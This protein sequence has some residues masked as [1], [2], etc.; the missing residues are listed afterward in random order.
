MQMKTPG[1]QPNHK[2]WLEAFDLRQQVFLQFDEFR[3]FGT[4]ALKPMTAREL[5]S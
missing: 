1:S 2:V 5:I 4:A 3:N